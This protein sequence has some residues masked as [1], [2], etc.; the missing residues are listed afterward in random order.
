MAVMVP[1]FCKIQV[2]LY[3]RQPVVR[4]R[5]FEKVEVAP[6]CCV[7]DPV[8][9]IAKSVVVAD[10]VDEPIAKRVVLVE[11]LFVCIESAAYG[12]VVPT[13]IEVELTVSV[14]VEE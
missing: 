2:P 10:A 3:W 8:L 6:P 9:E 12:D 14:G 5:P 11:P 4:L 13:P 1:R 7:R